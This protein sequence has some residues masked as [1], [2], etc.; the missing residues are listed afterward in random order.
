M[1]TLGVVTT[2][3]SAEPAPIADR[4]AWEPVADYVARQVSVITGSTDLVADDAPDA[5]HA[6]RVAIRRLRS[7]LRTFRPLWPT[8]HK[9]LLAELKWYAGLLG[10]PRDLEVMEEWLLGLTDAEDVEGLDDLRA[11]V[12]SRLDRE[13][14]EAL[15]PLRSELKGVRYGELVPA[16]AGLADGPWSQYGAV[17]ADLLLPGL[18]AAPAVRVDQL[19]SQLG[20]SDDRDEDLHTLRKVAKAA[21]YAY[22]ALGPAAKP[23]AK[24]WKKVT[25]SLGIVQDGIV[26]RDLLATSRDR[27]VAAGESAAP[28]DHMIGVLGC[29]T[30]EAEAAGFE[31]LARGHELLSVR[32]GDWADPEI[33]TDSGTGSSPPTLSVG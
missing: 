11:R 14:E 21:R 17:P 16:L 28:Y 27:A 30:A 9:A 8:G 12:R 33:C 4:V 1:T 26:G 19:A 31:A 24:T 25:E 6:T 13:R 29:V 22:E 20:A 18:A 15:A 23:H 5:I 10:V 32:P 2:E 7:V 3:N